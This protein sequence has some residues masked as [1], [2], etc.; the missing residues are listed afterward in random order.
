MRQAV[1]NI[2]QHEVDGARF[3]DIAAGS[4]SMG[5]EALSR[6][7]DSCTFI[8]HD[9]NA[10]LAIYKNIETCAVQA[11]SSVLCSDALLALKRLEK[12]QKSFTVAYFDPPYSLKG[13]NSPFTEEVLTFL[14]A[15]SIL[16]PN[17][18]LFLE[19]SAYFDLSKCKLER[20]QL[21]NKRRFGSSYLYY[22]MHT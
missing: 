3:L 1:F 13:V 16:A 4:G 12:E 18:C 6:G 21:Q 20:L 2:A 11:Q 14:D 22:F 8:E 19:E 17:G 9:K 7:A 5:L 10:V 15:S